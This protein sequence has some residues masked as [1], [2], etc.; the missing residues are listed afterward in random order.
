LILIR[1]IACRSDILGGVFIALL[2]TYLV[3]IRKEDPATTGFVLNNAFGYS[4]MVL[5]WVRFFNTVELNGALHTLSF[6]G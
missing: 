2:A 5:Q 3:Y 4:L 1:W 6:L